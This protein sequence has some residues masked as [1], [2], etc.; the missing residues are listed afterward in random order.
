MTGT[1]PVADPWFTIEEV[2]PGVHRITEPH[3]HRLVRAN[4]HLVKGSARDL[5]I[6]SGMGVGR[7]RDAVAP[8]IDKPLILFTTHAHVDHRGGHREFRDAEIL[9]HPAEADTLR[10]TAEVGS[11]TFDQFDPDTL[12]GLAG[13]GFDTGG[14][15]VDA[16]PWP[17]FDI[18]ACRTEGVEP[19]R[20]VGEGDEVDI[21]DRR[22]QVLH[23]PGHSPGGIALW[24]EDTGTLFAGDVIYDGILIDDLPGSD[25]RDY[26]ETM[27]RLI[28]LPVRVVHGGHRGEFGG[29]RMRGIASHYIAGRQR[30]NQPPTSETAPT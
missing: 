21:G 17:G 14:L 6:D 8:L 28:D 18:A 11:L 24:E 7:L 16:V 9:V 29:D 4:S 12:R 19:T 5:L 25:I 13:A 3:C 20:L 10:T 30:N 2:E 26:V 1:L 27:R 23:L 15:L 22:F